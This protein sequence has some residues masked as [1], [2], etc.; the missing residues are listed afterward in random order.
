[1]KILLTALFV[2][3]IV[4]SIT[5]AQESSAGK[6]VK[7]EELYAVCKDV[8]DTAPPAT[9]Q[10][11]LNTGECN[12]YLT[13][14]SETITSTIL[15]T[16]D[17]LNILVLADGM[18]TPKLRKAFNDFM[19]A[20]PSKIVAQANAEEVLLAVA[21]KAGMVKSVPVSFEKEEQPESNP[22]KQ[23]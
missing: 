12:G 16:D 11:A 23:L 22:K 5:K 7:A 8:S 19:K 4:V 20:H 21:L 17:S 2:L 13:G 18:T 1:M 6:E 9:V 14:W 15:P 3:A 10:T